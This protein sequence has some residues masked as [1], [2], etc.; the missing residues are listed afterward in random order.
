MINCRWTEF[1]LAHAHLTHTGA[2]PGAVQ[3]VLLLQR[4][5]VRGVSGDHHAA[6]EQHL[7]LPRVQGAGAAGGHGARPDRPPG[8]LRGGGMPERE[9][10]GVRAGPRGRHRRLPR[11]PPA[12]PLLDPEQPVPLP[13]PGARR[14]SESSPVPFLLRRRRRRQGRRDD[15]G[16]SGH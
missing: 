7:Q 6:A 4:D 3:R 8:R 10:V 15:G 16:A 13:P 2:L 14:A 1:N 11:R 12:A 5:G 9:D